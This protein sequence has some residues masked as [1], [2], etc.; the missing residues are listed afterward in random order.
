[1]IKFAYVGIVSTITDYI[2]YALLLYFQTPYYFAIVV[3]YSAG[4]VVNFFLTRRYVFTKCCR[5]TSVYKEFLA[6]SIVSIVAIAL[7]IAIVG[8]LYNYGANYYIGRVVAI[9][10]I[11]FFNYFTRKRYIYNGDEI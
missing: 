9:V 11:F 4:V 3:G 6:V 8:I 1:M 10:L 5:F 2:V 7:N